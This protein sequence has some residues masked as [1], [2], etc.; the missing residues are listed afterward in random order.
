MGT[1]ATR[2]RGYFS[3][4]GRVLFWDF[5]VLG[6]GCVFLILGFGVW[7]GLG[8][9]LRFETGF[10]RFVHDTSRMSEAERG[11][12]RWRNKCTASPQPLCCDAHNTHE[13]QHLQV[14]VFF[15]SDPNPC[16]NLEF[17]PQAPMQFPGPRVRC[18]LSDSHVS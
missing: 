17:T 12:T 18:M 2:R 10:M 11:K 15:C 6:F 3:S 8:R 4:F 7:V 14:L 13:G 1:E 9:V 5:G 16:A